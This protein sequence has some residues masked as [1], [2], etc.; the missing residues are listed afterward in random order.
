MINTH[1]HTHAHTYSFFHK[2]WVSKMGRY[3][4]KQ[5]KAPKV[6]SLVPYP[7]DAISGC[8]ARLGFPLGNRL[9]MTQLLS[10]CRQ[11]SCPKLTPRAD[12]RKGEPTC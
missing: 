11:G 2:K 3:D 12:W 6:L 10:Y 1:T 5:R 8:P 7:L 4:R 9:T